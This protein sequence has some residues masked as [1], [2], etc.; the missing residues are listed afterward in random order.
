MKFLFSIHIDSEY[1]INSLET[2]KRI[3]SLD[4][5][6]DNVL[7]LLL[8][9]NINVLEVFNMLYFCEVLNSDHCWL[10]IMYVSSIFEWHA[11][12]I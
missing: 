6:L 1:S 8:L 10:K 5:L 7:L 9:F 11:G 2:K 3:I 4:Y 12:E